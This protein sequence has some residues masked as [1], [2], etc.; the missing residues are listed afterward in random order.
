VRYDLHEICM[1]YFV[2]VDSAEH[3]FTLESPV[4]AAR[5][6]LQPAHPAATPLQVELLCRPGTDG[7]AVVLVDG[8]VF[9]VR[10][11]AARAG[12]ALAEARVNGR[13]VRFALENELE[14]RSRPARS[15]TA[16][17]GARVS[18][19]MPGRVVKVAVRVGDIVS[20]GAGLLSIEAMKMENEVQAP[21]DGRVVRVTVEA[22]ATVEADQE[23]ILIEPLSNAT[24]SNETISGEMTPSEPVTSP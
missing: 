21:C 15:R 24:V 17:S 5:A 6:V 14:R 2:T 23:L 11:Q 1:R 20:A 7:T 8:H 9:R 19:P 10:R 16:V 12:G 13:L 4:S 22:G 3:A 18:A